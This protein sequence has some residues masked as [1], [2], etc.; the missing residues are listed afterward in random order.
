MKR[1][2]FMQLMAATGLTAHL[3]AF[4]TR[5]H[6]AAIPD[7]YLVVI[8]AGGGWDPT[9][10]CDPKGLNKAYANNSDR[11]EG[12]TNSVA[13]DN[14]K[15]FGQIQWSA[16]P[17]SVS[18]DAPARQLIEQQFDQFFQNYGNRLTVVNGIDNGTNNHDTGNRVTWSG[19][20]ETGYPSISALYAA[21]ISPTLPMSFISNGGYDFTDSLVARARANSASFINEI[22]DPNFYYQDDK[23]KI[24]HGLFYRTSNKSVDIYQTI[25]AAQKARIQRQ[26]QQEKLPQKRQQLN[27]LFGV[28]STDSNLS[29][30]K[31]HLDDIQDNVKKEQHWNKNHANRLKSQAEVITAA[32]KANLAVSANLSTGGFDTH[33]DHDRRAYPA[34]GDLLEGVHFL[35]KALEHAGI[36]NKTTIVMG[37]DFGRTPYYNSGNGKDHWPLTSMMVLHPETTGGKVFGASTNN[38]RSQKINRQTGLPDSNGEILKPRHVH[39]ALR[40]LMGIENNPVIKN[41]PLR[42]DNFEIFS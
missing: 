26:Q 37:S 27:Q 19:H 22:S 24:K 1:R 14:N 15:K 42:A 5:A 36:A 41:Y 11:H 35:Q 25:Q 18:N 33:G 29:A 7:R 31:V 6:A 9:S 13:L 30:L 17:E 8:N 20:E 39:L 21:A 38:F 28:R 10:L 2:D 3:P 40:K 23:T 4:S 16:I 34:L 12:S 32:F